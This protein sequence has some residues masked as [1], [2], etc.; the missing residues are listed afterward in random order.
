MLCGGTWRPSLGNRTLAPSARAARG[1]VGE[2][3]FVQLCSSCFHAAFSSVDKKKSSW[4]SKLR[5]LTIFAGILEKEIKKYFTGINIF[6]DTISR[7]FHINICTLYS[8]SNVL[9]LAAR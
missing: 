5:K 6:T 9:S 3:G 4:S 8:V 7:S 1:K 2:V